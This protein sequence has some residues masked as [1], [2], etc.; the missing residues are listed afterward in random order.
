MN[1]NEKMITTEELMSTDVF[2]QIEKRRTMN[3][4]T[5]FDGDIT[6][7]K[8]CNLFY[9]GKTGPGGRK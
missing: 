9:M 4:W 7:F 5:T 3:V 2:R 1:Q 8:G 6:H